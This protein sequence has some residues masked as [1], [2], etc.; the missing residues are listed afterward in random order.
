MEIAN[1]ELGAHYKYFRQTFNWTNTYL[2]KAGLTE[3]AKHIENCTSPFADPK[4]AEL[5]E[6]SF[7]RIMLSLK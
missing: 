7:V 2:Q 3:R 5:G 4:E 6:L 1:T